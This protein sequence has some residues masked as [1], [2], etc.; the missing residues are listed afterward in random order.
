MKN[1]LSLAVVSFLVLSCAIGSGSKKDPY[2][3]QKDLSPEAKELLKQAYLDIPGDT[4]YD[5]HTHLVGNSPNNGTYV[6]PDW[7][8]A[9]HL[10]SYIMYKVYKSASGV[11][12]VDKLDEQYVQRLV[13]LIKTNPYPVKYGLMAFDYYYNDDGSINK[14]LSTFHVPNEYMMKVVSEYPQYF[15]PIISIHPYRKDAVD[16]LK[17]YAEQ[18]VKYIKWLPNSMNINA[19]S[20]KHLEQLKAYYAVMKEYDMAL[21]THTGYE[22]ATD[23][24]DT[25]KF[26]DPRYLSLPLE[27]GVKVVM[28]HVASLGNCEQDVEH[29]HEEK[30]YFDVAMG[31][32][33]DPKYKGQLF[34]D[35]SA[36]ILINRE[37][38]VVDDIIDAEEIHDRL[39]N[40]SDYPVPAINVLVKTSSFVKGGNITE[41][42]GELL[43]E[44][45]D[46]N[47]LIYDF[48]LKRT[49]RHSKTG[50][51]LPEFIF[52]EMK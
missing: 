1:I 11:T 28:A 46:Y 39:I 5:Y 2:A 37:D 18:G 47:P 23:G 34:A 17:K 10:K 13:D 32:L 14:E 16:E 51:K 19:S 52:G 8:S 3:M 26:G 44:I 15:F 45:F 9:I 43:N 41:K 7:L 33:K 42:E 20:K 38:N 27:M 24:H 50:K 21:I 35:I 6:N 22:K 48:V 29:C 49:L 12:D 4:A 30:P 31:M 36:T 40:G 25:Q